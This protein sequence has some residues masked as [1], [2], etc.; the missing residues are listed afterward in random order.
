M[1]CSDGLWLPAHTLARVVGVWSPSSADVSRFSTGTVVPVLGCCSPESAKM[2]NSAV[3]STATAIPHVCIVVGNFLFMAAVSPKTMT[4]HELRITT[5]TVALGCL[6]ALAKAAVP[7]TC[8]QAGTDET[9]QKTQ[10]LWAPL[11]RETLRLPRAA[12][13]AR[14]AKPMIAM[15]Q[16]R[17]TKPPRMLT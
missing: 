8:P 3:A 2:V 10:L 15:P 13:S 16:R 7:R 5:K 6:N 11:N 1:L 9:H 17:N 14:R 4:G 12:A